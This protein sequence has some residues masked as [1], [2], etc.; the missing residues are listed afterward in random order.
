MRRASGCL[1]SRYW[2]RARRYVSTRQIWAS[3]PTKSPHSHLTASP[4]F[5][6]EHYARQRGQLPCRLPAVCANQQ[7]VRSVVGERIGTNLETKTHGVGN[8][9]DANTEKRSGGE[10]LSWVVEEFRNMNG[11]LWVV[12]VAGLV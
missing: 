1:T 6:G 4:L 9:D 11:N 7:R 10:N 3:P 12:L 2:S 5:R 8:G